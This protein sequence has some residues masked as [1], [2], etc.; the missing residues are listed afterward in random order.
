MPAERVSFFVR[1]D[2]LPPFLFSPYPRARTATSRRVIEETKAVAIMP[3]NYH[4]GATQQIWRPVHC[5][6]GRRLLFLME[7]F[8]RRK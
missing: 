8:A 2:I 4:V 5:T 6:A 1:Q 7:L 3:H